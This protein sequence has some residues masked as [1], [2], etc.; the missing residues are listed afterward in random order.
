MFPPCSCS[1]SPERV[2]TPDV[3]QVPGDRPLVHRSSSCDRGDPPAEHHVAIWS[4][5]LTRSRAIS[6][7]GHRSALVVHLERRSGRP[8]QLVY[9][10]SRERLLPC[11]SP[12]QVCVGNH[13]RCPGI[14]VSV[15]EKP[16]DAGRYP[17]TAH[18]KTYCGSCGTMHRSF[19]D[20]TR[21]QVRDLS[22]GPFR[23]PSSKVAGSA[24]KPGF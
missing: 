10:G 1:S 9:K 16:A 21:R 8:Q 5:N 20:R 14:K 7:I 2:L 24:G 18:K 19:Y 11:K 13:S 3:L 23:I 17:R 4:P 6:R 12:P 22:S 15:H